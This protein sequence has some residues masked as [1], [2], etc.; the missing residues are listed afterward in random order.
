MRNSIDSPK[1]LGREQLVIP[2][3]V[4]SQL[5][6]SLREYLDSI[7]DNAGKTPKDLYKLAARPG[8]QRPDMKASELVAWF[9]KDRDLGHGHSMAICKASTDKRWV[10]APSK[11]T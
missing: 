3:E 10:H 4:A 11:K 5:A 7:K 2:W 6:V 9:K 1:R 8:V